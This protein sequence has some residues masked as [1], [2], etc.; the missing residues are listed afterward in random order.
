MDIYKKVC[1]NC[2]KVIQSLY[3][4]Q[5]KY[6]FE[7]HKL[8]CNQRSLHKTDIEL[9]M[10]KALEDNEINFV[11]QYPIRCKY[12]YIADFYLP[13]VNLIVECDGERWHTK[14][15]DNTKTNVLLKLGF[16]I[17]RFKGKEIQENIKSCIQKINTIVMKGGIKSNGES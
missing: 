11:E 16:K 2:G 3:P 9:I 17:L 6:N 5:L 14:K 4:E 13:E 7:A 15:K 8:S 12:G 1:D 10:K